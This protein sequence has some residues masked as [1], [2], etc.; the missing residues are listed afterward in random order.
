M[1]SLHHS[2]A[3]EQ[4]ALESHA[5]LTSGARADSKETLKWGGEGRGGKWKGRLRVR[6]GRGR[7][8][9]DTAAPLK[10]CCNKEDTICLPA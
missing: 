2:P 9:S 3:G 7:L 10:G 4:R 5:Q 8:Q 1:H 6:E